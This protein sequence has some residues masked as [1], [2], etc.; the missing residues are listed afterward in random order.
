MATITHEFLPQDAV[1]ATSNYATFDAMAG[2]NFVV[3]CLDFDASTDES[4]FFFFNAVSYGSGNLTV[5]VQWY[6]DTASS[7]DVVWAAQLACITPNTDS[8]DIETKAFDTA[9]TATDSHLGTTNQRLHSVDITVSN[10][11][12]IAAGDYCVLKIYR[13]ADNGSDTMTGDASL[14]RVLV[15]YSDT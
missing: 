6:A 10:T 2:S 13:D 8:T 3:P 9:N 15:S 1:P 12:S 7:G 5:Q 11:D 14:V 4:A